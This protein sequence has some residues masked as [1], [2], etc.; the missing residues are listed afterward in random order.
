M[1]YIDEEKAH[2]R[3]YGQLLAWL[4]AHGYEL[5]T[6]QLSVLKLVTGFQNEQLII[7]T[8]QTPK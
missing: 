2:G 5:A 8:F 4:I 6:C 1:T 7:K 3:I